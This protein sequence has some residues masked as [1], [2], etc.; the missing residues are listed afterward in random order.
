MIRPIAISLSPNTGIDDVLAAIKIISSPLSWKHG[1]AVEKVENWFNRRFRAKVSVSFNSGRSALLAILSAAGIGPG[2]EVII[3]AF[4]CVA[5]PDPVVWSGAKP[6]YVDI[7]DSLNID[8]HLLEQYI[9]SKTRAII[10]QHTFGIPANIEKTKKIAQKHE[11]ILIEDCAHSLGAKV[12]NREVG[13]FGDAAF[14][15]FGRD[16]VISSVFGGMAIINKHSKIDS[17]KLKHYQLKLP[18]PSIF[19]I[20]QQLL[21]PLVF[22]IVLPFYNIYIGKILLYFFQR[23][24]LLSFPVYSCE[25]KAEKP[26]VFP[27]KYPNALA[28]LLLI[29]LPKLEKF[30]NHRKEIARYYFSSLKEVKGLTLPQETPGAIYLRFNIFIKNA[31]DLLTYAKREGILLGNWY[32]RIIDPYGVSMEAIGFREGNYIK[33]KLA[34]RESVN[35]PTYQ[36][37]SIKQAEKVIELIKQYGNK[38]FGK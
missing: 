6:V 34:A 38:N 9:T 31:T 12:G 29:Q 33:A 28:R 17:S 8:P 30:N 21:H 1:S 2:D 16:K 27:A 11:L 14:F 25:K 7:D 13:T 19:W 18:S 37:M 35:L 26:S 10:V 32:H 36:A 24:H 4:T 5:V 22:F 23:L 15:S 20:F 3:Q